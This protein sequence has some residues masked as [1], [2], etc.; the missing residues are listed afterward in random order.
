MKLSVAAP[1]GSLYAVDTDDGIS[2]ARV[3]GPVISDRAGR[4]DQRGPNELSATLH[5]DGLSLAEVRKL[6]GERVVILVASPQS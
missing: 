2:V 6:Q 3:V 5:V 1:D 4:D